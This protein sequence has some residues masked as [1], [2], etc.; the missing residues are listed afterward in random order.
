MA[1]T[2]GVGVGRGLGGVGSGLRTHSNQGAPFGGGLLF[3]PLTAGTKTTNRVAASTTT[4]TVVEKPFWVRILVLP[5]SST[6][7]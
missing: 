7:S 1:G 2:Q 6:C 3:A 5:P 4:S